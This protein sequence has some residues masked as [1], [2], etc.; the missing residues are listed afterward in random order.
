[1][2]DTSEREFL[3]GNGFRERDCAPS[4]DGDAVLEVTGL[5]KRYRKGGGFVVRGLS[6]RCRAGEITALTGANGAGKSTTLKCIAGI[7]PFEEGRIEICGLS[8]RGNSA[9]AKRLMGYVSDDH[10][11]IP[12]MS[13]RQFLRFSADV[14]GVTEDEREER[15]KYLVG[16]LDLGGVLDEPIYTYSHGTK[17]KICMAGS[18]IGAPR[19]WILDEPVTG[20]DVRS[21]AEVR[22]LMR[23]F[24]EGGGCVLFSSHDLDGI[25]KTCTR[26]L[27]VRDGE[28]EETSVDDVAARTL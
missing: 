12:Y 28:A 22:A 20:L 21:A 1:M 4:R 19:L 9:E 18:L 26:V 3:L 2:N 8:V 13:G 17:Q 24:A 25:V 15:V 11:V 23:E 16:R 10:A 6:F 27:V 7:L 5:G 14:R